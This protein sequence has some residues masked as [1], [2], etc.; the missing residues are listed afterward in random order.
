MRIDVTHRNQ[1]GALGSALGQDMV[2]PR[3]PVRIEP[4]QPT[5]YQEVWDRLFATCATWL[6]ED[7]CHRLLG[8]QPFLCPSADRPMTAN[9]WFWLAAGALG[10]VIA[11]KLFL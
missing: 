5:N 10:G 3:E 7:E 1:L 2:F 4:V 9:W 11:G 8:Y 6:G